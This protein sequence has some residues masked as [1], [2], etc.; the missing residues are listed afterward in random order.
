MT[1]PAR[2]QKPNG[3]APLGTPEAFLDAMAEYLGLAALHAELAQ[4][5]A[6]AGDGV[7]LAYAMRKFAAYAKAALGTF[8]D[9]STWKSKHKESG[10]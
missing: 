5:Y 2:V 9:L 4:T 3:T 6:D 8:D 1:S 7:G 10:I